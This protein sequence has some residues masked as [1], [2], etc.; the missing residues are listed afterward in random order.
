MQKTTQL[1]HLIESP[2]ILVMPGAYDALS[3]KIVEKVGFNAI[4]ATGYGIAATVFAKPDIGIVSMGDMLTITRHIIQAV[5]IPV[6]AD[7]DTGFGNPINVYHTV[8]YFEQAGAAGI[9]L[10]DQVFPKRCGHLEGK[11]VISSEEMVQ[12]IRAAVK[13]RRDPD[14]VINARTDAIAIY[15]VEEAVKRGNAYAQAGADLIFVD[16]PRSREEIEYVIKNIKAPVSINMTPGGKSPLCTVAELEQMGA[17]RVSFPVVALFAAAKN[18]LQ[19]LTT[20]KNTGSLTPVMDQLMSFQEF[21]QLVGLPE[22]LRL[23]QE[24]LSPETLHEKYHHGE[25]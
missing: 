23:E 5:D 25:K 14:F 18:M 3:A 15:G 7:G 20:L 8:L 2:Q 16:A 22:I 6:M 24:F 4:Q 10:E 9:N 13:A 21:T 12:K 19:T 1:K 11:Q 17:A